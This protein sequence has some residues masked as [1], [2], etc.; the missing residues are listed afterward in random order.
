MVEVKSTIAEQIKTLKGAEFV[1]ELPVWSKR[2]GAQLTCFKT[3]LILVHKDKEPHKYDEAEKK[4]IPITEGSPEWKKLEADAKREADKKKKEAEKK[5]AAKKK[6]AKKKK[7]PEKL[8]LK[9]IVAISARYEFTD[10]E[11]RAIAQELARRNIDKAQVEDEKKSVMSDFK[12]RLDRINMDVNKASRQLVD[13]FEY[14]DFSCYIVKHFKLGIKRY[15]D[16]NTD[17]VVDEKPLDPS[18]YQLELGD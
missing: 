2:K 9:R 14:R 10:E 7:L 13:G 5:K 11:K 18:D 15:H 4:W 3:T 17:K 16:K 8:R 1:C 12:D 6:P